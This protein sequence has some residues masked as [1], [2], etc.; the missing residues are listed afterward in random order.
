MTGIHDAAR[1]MRGAKRMVAFTGAGI[2][3]ESG[4]PD[5]RSNPGRLRALAAPPPGGA[6]Q[7]PPRALAPYDPEEFA[8]PRYVANEGS[9][10]KYWAWG[11][12]LWPTV[13]DA[14]P[15]PAHVALAELERRGRLACVITQNIDGLHQKAGSRDVIEL[16]GNTTRVSCLS[17]GATWPRDA[18]HARLVAGEE[19]PRCDD[20]ACGGIL[21]PTTISFGQAMPVEE[22]RRAFS[23]A[24]NCDLLLTVGSSLVVYPAAEL[25]PTARAAGARIMLVNLSP[26][27]YDGLADVVVRGK[28]GDALAAVLAALAPG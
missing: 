14:L 10:K 24:R 5:F 28:A 16:H 11:K 19:D 1:L 12:E 21:K 17:C 20:A 4:I 6:G 2:S 27:P 23:E 18:I 25:V 7:G 8:F 9:R 26:T 13:R 3:T 22:T 15:N